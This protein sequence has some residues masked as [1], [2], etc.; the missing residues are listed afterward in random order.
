MVDV[1]IVTADTRDMVLASVEH[2]TDATI[3]RIVVVDNG[4]S[5]GT[6]EAI[7]DRFPEV[8]LVRLDE[9]AGF[10]AACNR[11]AERGTAEDILFLNSDVFAT[12]DAV[13][14]LARELA[15]RPDCVAA[16]GRLVEPDDHSTQRRYAPRRFPTLATFTVQLT[17]V[18]RL[19]PGN[20][21]TRRDQAELDDTTIVA[22]DQPAAACL[23][24]RRPT[25]EAVG[26]FDERYWFWYEDVDLLRRLADEGTILYVPMAAFV[27]V[28]G[29]TF[30][31]WSRPEIVRSRYDGLLR[32]VESHFSRSA[33]IGVALV[34][35][36]TSLPRVVVYGA[37]RS[38]LG[39]A[40]RA[41]VG[42]AASLLGG[43]AV[44]A[45]ANR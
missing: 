20:P 28:G 17:G 7:G 38:E 25:F 30:R 5:D 24:V 10:A 19:W 31:R 12:P 39:R 35:I 22:V 18:E 40:Y 34:V 23:L 42:A 21:I 2:L 32:Y 6:A 36:A 9:P 29:G 37:T 15:A 43:R 13:D 16:G 8:T 3:D 33:Q 41:V 14:T 44:P 27:H 45:L 11:G 26:G 4:S 1:V